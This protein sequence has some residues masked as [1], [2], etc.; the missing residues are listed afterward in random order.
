VAANSQLDERRAF[1][2]AILSGVSAGVLSVDRDGIILLLNSSAAA[3]LVREGDDP[4]GRPL[5]DV[6]PELAELLQSEEGGGIVQ[7]RTNG[8]V[9][10]LAVKVS[11][12]ASRH[13]LTFDDITQQ[14][15]DQ[16]R[17][18][19]SDPAGGGTAATALFRRGNQRQGDLHPP[20]RHHR[21]AGR[22]LAAD[23]G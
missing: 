8:D 23:R 10:T 9:R 18:A 3:I 21:S 5:T 2:E 17:A 16:R 15:S 7:I 19:W 14:L 22:R 13:I 12:D 4:V 1:S 6:S 20:D 11:E